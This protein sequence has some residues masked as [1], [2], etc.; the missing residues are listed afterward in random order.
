MS[1]SDSPVKK[2][3]SSPDEGGG[4]DRKRGRVSWLLG[5]VGVPV[6]VIGLIFGAGV[7]V[8]VHLHE[9]WFTR[10]VVWFVGLF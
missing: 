4:E 6:L 8:G 2:Q 9:S 3:R 1:D 7:A 5:W 10:L